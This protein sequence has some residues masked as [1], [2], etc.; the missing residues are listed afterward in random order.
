M[1]KIK[2]KCCKKVEKKGKCCQSCPLYVDIKRAKKKK[3]KK[4]KKDKK[5]K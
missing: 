1:G 5:K 3:Q 2:K 4:K